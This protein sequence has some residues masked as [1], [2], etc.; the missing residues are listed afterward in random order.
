MDI[1]KGVLNPQDIRFVTEDNGQCILNF[2]ILEDKMAPY[3]LT[4]CIVRM[5]ID[6][7]QQDC[8][9]V[10]ATDG[11]V[12]IELE[13]SMFAVAGDY[14]AELQIYDIANQ[15]KRLTTPT[16]R[17]NVRKSMMDDETV[18]ADP[19]F[20]I[21][22]GMIINVS[23]ANDLA[24][25]AKSVADS[26]LAT[27]NTAVNNVATIQAKGDYAKQ[28]GDYAKQQGDSMVPYQQEITHKINILDQL[29]APAD[30][31]KN[32]FY[33]Q[34]RDIIR[35]GLVDTF[36]NST[37]NKTS[38]NVTDV[39][40]VCFKGI[41][42]NI[43]KMSTDGVWYLIG[44]NINTYINSIGVVFSNTGEP[45][46]TVIFPVGTIENNKPFYIVISRNKEDMFFYINGVGKKF[47]TP[48]NVTS[49]NL[50]IGSYGS[51]F[52]YG[53]NGKFD[54][55]VYNRVLSQQEI[56]YN[57]SSMGKNKVQAIEKADGT[58]YALS[59]LSEDVF[60]SN[61]MN[62]DMAMNQFISWKTLTMGVDGTF[63]TSKVADW[64][65][66][67]YSIKGNTVKQLLTIRLTKAN[68]TK[69]PTKVSNDNY[70]FKN[71]SIYTLMMYVDELSGT[72]TV[73]LNFS[74][75]FAP[76]DVS[77]NPTKIG[78]YTKTFTVN[79][80][81]DTTHTF[82]S[83]YYF[84]NI[85]TDKCIIS[86]VMM[87][88]GSQAPNV[89]S[90]VPFGLS[91]VGTTVGGKT[92]LSYT[93]NG[94]TNCFELPHPFRK[95]DVLK[96]KTFSTG[97]AEIT[98]TGNENEWVTD[99]LGMGDISTYC[100]IRDIP[101]LKPSS[102]PDC[103]LFNWGRY[104]EQSSSGAVSATTVLIFVLPHTL[105]GVIKTD[106][107]E[108]VVSK[109]K[110]YFKSIYDK[111]TPAI[112]Q[113]ELAQPTSQSIKSTFVVTPDSNGNADI[114]FADAVTPSSAEIQVAQT[115]DQK[116]AELEARLVALEAKT[117]TQPVNKAFIDQTYTQSANKINEVIKQ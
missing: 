42:D 83:L 11:T 95:W 99:G 29:P 104:N 66:D 7:Q 113:Y 59:A 12:K 25:Q 68:I 18:Q 16:F 46:S 76:P 30:R 20:S 53:V 17:Y 6:E 40:T 116:N 50:P 48:N 10:M 80:Q 92:C 101:N 27:A 72:S 19:H 77:L 65:S 85:E 84:N 89:T 58:K 44:Q 111:G 24:N 49:G 31:T 115:A 21:L 57:F 82:V 23:N 107:K 37:S 79:G 8:T 70:M 105:T 108:Q 15:T 36:L 33:M 103:N 2:K 87:F 98:I 71:G 86:D 88:E 94:V 14:K 51:T 55:Y 114:R 63:P 81:V 91:S 45:N 1:Y 56:K 110:A 64:Y 26:A 62:L 9:T 102:K 60:F 117:N 61:G 34:N 90:Y 22:Q 109:F 5:L 73:N 75:G 28:Q 78:W 54:A 3:D 4:G 41:T 13:Q 47:K 97:C 69:S 106:T 67:R 112:V 96:D 52:D 74:G 100:Y 43:Q 38:T 35:D 39:W 93:C 32:G